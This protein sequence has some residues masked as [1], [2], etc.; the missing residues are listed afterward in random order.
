MPGK[1][2]KIGDICEIATPA[3]LAYVQYTHDGR[4]MGQLVRVL[5]GLFS[6]RPTDFAELSQQKERYFAFYTLSYA[7]RDHQ[8][9]V[10]SHR[11]Y[12]SGHSRIRSRAGVLDL[13]WAGKPLGNSSALQVI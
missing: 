11:Q 10:V 8:V 12:Q 7:L 13:A 4:G 3:G 9:E 1:K 5:P 2:A 6:T